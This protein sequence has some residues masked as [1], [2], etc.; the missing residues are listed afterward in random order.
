MHIDDLKCVFC[1]KK[2]GDVERLMMGPEWEK[3]VYV[4]AI[5][6]ECTQ[7]AYDTMLRERE[8]ES[9]RLAAESKASSP[10]NVLQLSTSPKMGVG[11]GVSVKEGS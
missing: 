1:N 9:E 3:E 5:C 2:V 8:R 11:T 4:P 6:S 10:S 7:V